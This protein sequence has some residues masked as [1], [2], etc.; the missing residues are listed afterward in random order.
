MKISNIV[1][2]AG[3]VKDMIDELKSEHEELRSKLKKYAENKGKNVI[4]GKVY[5]ATF[6]DS[7]KTV[8]HEPAFWRF[9]QEEGRMDEVHTVVKPNVTLLKKEMKN[10]I[11]NFTT[12]EKLPKHILK[13]TKNFED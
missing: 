5:T 8:I 7:T 10:D 6:Q 9:L 11:E 4:K 13:M 2:R 12:T 3:E 1:D